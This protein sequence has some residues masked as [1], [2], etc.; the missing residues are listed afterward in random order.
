M[1]LNEC[2]K[3]TKCCEISAHILFRTSVTH[4]HCIYTKMLACAR[5]RACVCGPVP[6]YHHVDRIVCETGDEGC[7]RDEEDNR[8]EEVRAAVG[9]GPGTCTTHASAYHHTAAV[10]EGLCGKTEGLTTSEDANR[11]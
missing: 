1:L 8:Q 9:T 11:I 3:L 2:K 5:V 4:M 7:Y 6:E 10:I